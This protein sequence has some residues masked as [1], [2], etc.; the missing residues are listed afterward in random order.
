M[1]IASSLGKRSLAQSNPTP[2]EGP[3]LKYLY[4]LY[5][6]YQGYLFAPAATYYHLQYIK[7]VQNMTL[8]QA[9]TGKLHPLRFSLSLSSFYHPL[10]SNTGT[11]NAQDLVVSYEEGHR[12]VDTT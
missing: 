4:H 8:S 9:V 11:P 7:K 3:R 1:G 2:T 10:I 5:R 12:R 6:Q